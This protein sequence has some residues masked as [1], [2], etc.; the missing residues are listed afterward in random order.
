MKFDTPTPLL[1]LGDGPDLLSGLG[2][3]GHDLAWLLS[4]MPEFNVGY[5]GRQS[6]G[7]AKFP[8]ATY[9]FSPSEQWG[10]QRIKEAWQDLSGGKRGV[11]L[12]VWD[13]SRLLWFADGRGTGLQDWYDQRHF[14]R[15]GYFMVD[16]AGVQPDKLPMEQAHVMANYDR[17]LIASRWG[18]HLAKNS[19]PP[20]CDL[21]WMPHPINRNI[22]KPMDRAYGRSA[23]GVANDV[24]LI[25]CVMTNQERK[26]WA[27]AIATLALLPKPYRMWIHT[28]VLTKSWNILALATEY[29][30]VD[31]LIWE[32]SNGVGRALS[33]T[34]LAMRY[35]ACDATFLISGCE[36]FA[37]PVA[38]SL[39]CGTPVIVGNYGAQGDLSPWHVAP[40]WRR[41]ETTH[42]VLR[43]EYYPWAFADQI[44][45]VISES[46]DGCKREECEALVQHLHMPLLGVQWKK[47]FRKGLQ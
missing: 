46:K 29:G 40:S 43:A 4:S 6:F 27:T 31:R 15:W 45:L 3:I 24:P 10:E 16:S 33:D 44:E 8:W 20:E 18:H 25:G 37:Y 41:I 22:F 9:T 32:G 13:A 21:D 7:R 19:L 14:E 1:I 26:H 5:L 30:V 47:W 38:E 17:V 36:G 34:E 23:L 35:S 39:S 11:I 28:D 12:T 2:R 42:N